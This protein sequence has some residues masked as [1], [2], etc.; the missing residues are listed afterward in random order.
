MT[1]SVAGDRHRQ[2]CVMGAGI[3]VMED[4]SCR[5]GFQD[6][7]KGMA[8]KRQAAGSMRARG[9]CQKIV[10][11]EA[12]PQDEARPV[13]R[14]LRDD[15][16]QGMD[17]VIGT[18]QKPFAFLKGILHQR[19]IAEF[20]IAQPAMDQLARPLR[21]LAGKV[22]LL[23]KRNPVASPGKIACNAGAIDA[24][25]GEDDIE[26]RIRGRKG[27]RHGS[28]IVAEAGRA[29]KT[30]EPAGRGRNQR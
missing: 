19:E 21:G 26:G 17:E 2:A 6:V 4:A 7:G 18:C 16:P 8:G 23:E 13:A 30:P 25:A 1:G 10:E 27:V 14:C 28:V 12:E 15:E 3:G 11:P 20:Q 9:P 5:P 29:A 24:A 22:A